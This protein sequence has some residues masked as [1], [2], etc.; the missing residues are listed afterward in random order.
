MI[1]A[2]E[3]A[4]KSGERKMHVSQFRK[5][6]VMRF[7]MPPASISQVSIVWSHSKTEVIK[8][9]SNRCGG[10]SWPMF[11]MNLKARWLH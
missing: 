6:G 11:H 3:G 8:N 1:E 4:I 5:I 10:I 7:M 9:K 2:I